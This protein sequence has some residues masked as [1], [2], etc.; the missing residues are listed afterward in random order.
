MIFALRFNGLAKIIN[1]D[2]SGINV[3][4]KKPVDGRGACGS[5]IT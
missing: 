3:L 2:K 1:Q 4:T 5:V